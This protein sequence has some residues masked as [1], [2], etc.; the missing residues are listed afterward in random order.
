MSIIHVDILQKLIENWWPWP[1][2]LH[3]F[4]GDEVINKYT[5]TM[6]VIATLTKFMSAMY[7][8]MFQ[9][10]TEILYLYLEILRLQGH[11]GTINL[12]LCS[13]NLCYQYIH[14]SVL[15]Y[16]F[17]MSDLDLLFKVTELSKDIS[18]PNWWQIPFTPPKFISLVPLYLL[19]TP[20]EN[21][22]TF[23]NIELNCCI[24]YWVIRLLATL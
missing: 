21:Q 8:E 3:N 5:I 2:H 9:K 15:Q 11:W 23:Q 4:Q 20:I 13:L 1:I 10:S 24:L 18:A 12:K 14:V 22:W 19:K 16:P 7:T 6:K 17:K